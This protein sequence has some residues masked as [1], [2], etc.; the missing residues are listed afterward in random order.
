MKNPLHSVNLFAVTGVCFS[1]LGSISGLHAATH[2]FTG[3]STGSTDWLAGSGW[4]TTPA[5]ASNTVLAFG[6]AS[7][8]LAAGVAITSNNQNSGNFSLNSLTFGYTGP[9]TGTAPTFS[10]TGGPLEFVSNGATTPTMSISPAGTV[11]P[12]FSLGNDL[13]LTNNLRISQGSASNAATL[14]G[15]LSGTGTLNKAG[16]GNVT[17]SNANSSFSG[18]VAIESGSFTVPNVGNSG[19]N[20]ALGTHASITLGAASNAGQLTW[21]GT[22][23]TTDKIFTLGGSTGSGTISAS[24]VGQTLTVSSNLVSGTS[25]SNRS[26]GLAGSGN[27]VFNGTIR[28]GTGASGGVIS[29]T[30]SGSGEAT[31]ANNANTFT[32]SV[33]I[34]NGTLRANTIGSTTADGGLGRGSVISFGSTTTTGLLRWQGTTSETTD[35]VITLA[36]TTGGASIYSTNSGAVLRFTSNVSVTGSGAKILNILGGSGTVQLDGTIPDSAS[37]ATSFRAS[38]SGDAVAILTNTGNSF[39]GSVTINGNTAAKTVTLQVAS[40]GNTGGNSS[41]GQ[42]STINIGSDVSGSNNSLKYVG[43]GEDTNKIVNL[44]GTLGNATIDQ[45]GSGLLKFTSNLQVS[46]VGAKGLA[47]QGGA[48]KTGEFAGIIGDSTGGATSVSKSGA[49]TWT[50]SGVNTYSGTT[51]VF[52]GTLILKSA[53]LKDDADVYVSSGGTLNLD[54][55]GT[56]TVKQLLISDVPQYQ[57][58]WGGLTSSA[59]FKT[60]RITGTG[61]LNVTAGPVPNAYIFWATSKGL[62]NSAGKEQASGAD[63]DKDGIANGLEWILGGDPLTSSNAVLPQM[64]ALPGSIEVTF[65]RSDESEALAFPKIQWGSD[66]SGW[67]DVLIGA[68]SAPADSYGITVDVTERGTDPDF[69]KVTIPRSLAID[70]KLFTRLYSYLP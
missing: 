45:S 62:D 10:I 64:T 66:L 6:T 43:V 21:T 3:T 49:G 68:T 9:T 60:S 28:N 11:R 14:S 38:G 41:I 34:Q 70:G 20:S 18:A 13:V 44:A 5:S 17:L 55:A 32:G 19:S 2:T 30:K 53:Y 23:E 50:L 35:K 61:I 48:G 1:F 36:G 65:T 12:S 59:Q 52:N 4:D 56:D 25:I 57:G 29:L 16:A 7:Q 22:S 15:V 42:N 51:K 26:F 27:V 58:T 54:Y 33:S 8:T 39:T 47:F 40:I 69:I 31:V 67:T 24:T 63:P 46:G 37:G